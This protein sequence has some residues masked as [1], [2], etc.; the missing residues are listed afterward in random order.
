M[1]KVVYYKDLQT[2]SAFELNM[3]KET[4]DDYNVNIMI[5]RQKEKMKTNVSANIYQMFCPIK[6]LKHLLIFNQYVT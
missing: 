2:K 4:S 5:T 6:L 3:L 1:I